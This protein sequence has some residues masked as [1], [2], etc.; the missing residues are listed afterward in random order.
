MKKLLIISLFSL[1]L[2]SF[3]QEDSDSIRR[4]ELKVNVFNLIGLKVIDF[5]YEHLLDEQSSVGVSFFFNLKDNELSDF[6]DVFELYYNEKLAVTPYYRYNFLNR[7]TRAF[8]IEG[9]GM[10]NVQENFNNSGY[11]NEYDPVVEDYEATSNNFA[12]GVSVGGKFVSGK[13]FVFEIYGGFGR[14][15]YT[16]NDNIATDFVRRVGAS[17]GFRF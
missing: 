12:I 6:E 3:A 13:G 9:F 1:T 8:F 5:S 2:I 15:L 14:N 11:E 17:I 7:Y 16:S 10:Y 4:N